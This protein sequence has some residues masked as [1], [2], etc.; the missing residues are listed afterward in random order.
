MAVFLWRLY[1]VP[2][3]AQAFSED[4]FLT[5]LLFVKYPEWFILKLCL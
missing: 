4:I 2:E 3:A 1:D 5:M